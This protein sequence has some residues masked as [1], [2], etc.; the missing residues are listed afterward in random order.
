ME[1]LPQRPPPIPYMPPPAA[2]P[3]PRG[4]MLAGWA[5][6]PVLIYVVVIIVFGWPV[7]KVKASSPDYAFSYFM[8]IMMGGPLISGLV[9]L[10]VYTASR[11]SQLSSTIVFT[12]LLVLFTL[13]QL[14][15][16]LRQRTL[17]TPRAGVTIPSAGQTSAPSDFVTFTS[18]WQRKP[19]GR[20]FPFPSIRS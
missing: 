17:V 6:F 14:N 5:I 12:V 13:G 20:M 11:R 9:A 2:P 15:Q 8:G 16:G 19:R 10:I 18:S 7:E 1:S 3:K 4:G